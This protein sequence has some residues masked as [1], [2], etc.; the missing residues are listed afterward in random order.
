[1]A[2]DT[3]RTIE[4]RLSPWRMI[5]TIAVSAAFVLISLFITPAHGAIG[6]VVGGLG[7]AFFGFV[8][9]VAL[10]RLLALRGPIVTVSP[11]GVRDMRLTREIVP[12][13]AIH[14]ISTWSA[15]NQP[16][17]V[18]AVDPAYERALKLTTMARLTRPLNTAVGADGLCIASQGLKMGHEAL[19]ETIT[20]YWHRAR[21]DRT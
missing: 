6:E 13:S 1:M 2:I 21:G 9:L 7:V 4:I 18:L 8:A 20:A 3:T 5:G 14:G 10:W 16:A 11:R 15:Y 19:L 17:I 12:W